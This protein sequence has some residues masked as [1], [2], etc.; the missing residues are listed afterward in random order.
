[1]IIF[2]AGIHGV[3]KSYLCK[4]YSEN[5][6]EN[7]IHSS[8]SQ[9][10][11]QQLKVENWGADKYVSDIDRN[12]T[13]LLEALKRFQ[14]NELL[15]LDGHFVLLKSANEFECVPE[16]IF[17]QAKFSACILIETDLPTVTERLM[18]RDGISAEVD[19]DLFFSKERARAEYICKKIE[20]PLIKLNS[21]SQKDFNEAVNNLLKE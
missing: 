2:V 7:A 5:E 15:L 13:A 19:L 3:G 16:N 20:I 9:L 18:N 8:A 4:A 21:P 14:G 11:K 10:I 6:H 1:M 17:V 12:Q